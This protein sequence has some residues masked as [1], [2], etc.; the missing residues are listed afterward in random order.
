NTARMIEEAVRNADQGV[1]IS[2]EVSKCLDEITQ[3]NKR[4]NELIAEIAAAS[5]EQ[6]QGI[7]QINTAVTQM[8]QVTQANAANA[9]ESAS[10]A[11]ELS[12]Q[13]EEMMRMVDSLQA[14]VGGGRSGHERSQ[15]SEPKGGFRTDKRPSAARKPSLGQP[16]HKAPQSRKAEQKPVAA[17]EEVIPMDSEQEL[18]QF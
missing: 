4:S 11:E 9:E 14:L 15:R 13:A 18:S 1:E 16:A 2:Q 12:A 6:A 8:D 17:G 3:G 7:E 5:N 10:A